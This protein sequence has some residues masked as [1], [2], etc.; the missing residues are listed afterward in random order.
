MMPFSQEFYE[1]YQL[2]I[3]PACEESGAYA[4]RVDEQFFVGTILEAIY[5]QIAKADVIVADL[6]HRNP[7]VYYETGYAHALGKNVILLSQS[8]EDI[9]FDLKHY[10][11]IIYSGKLLGL[12]AELAKRL[13][14]LFDHPSEARPQR[15]EKLVERYEKDLPKE[16]EKGL[17]YQLRELIERFEVPP[18]QF[19]VFLSYSAIDEDAARQL[20]EKIATSGLRAFYARK[21]LNAGSPF[22]EEIRNALRSSCELWVL[23][24][25][26]SL[27]S[28]W[29]TTEWGAGWV[30]GKRV[31]P[32]LLRCSVEV[33]PERLRAVQ[34]VDYHETDRLISELQHRI[35]SKGT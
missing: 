27:K 31:I 14:W 17:I 12:R 11:H 3:K 28:Q 7:N 19:D 1:I 34:C 13:Q 5:N 21:D 20:C 16:R 32:I 26:S 8:A 30:L 15:N 22:T 18:H 23:I 35:D 6:S 10:Q 24:T 4:E 33:L 29:V 25:P 9:P 2:A